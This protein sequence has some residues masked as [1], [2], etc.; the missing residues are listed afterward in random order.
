MPERNGLPGI[1]LASLFGELA[2]DEVSQGEV[3]VV[4]ADEQVVADRDA[5]SVS[6]P[7]S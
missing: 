3:H 7:S 6:S 4:A 2:G 5:P 1:E